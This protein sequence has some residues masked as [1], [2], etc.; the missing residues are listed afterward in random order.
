MIDYLRKL[1]LYDK[2]AIDRTIATLTEPENARARL[3]LAHL[4]WAEKIWMMR[5][6]G[7]DSSTQSNFDDLS[8]PECIAMAEELQDAYSKYLEE[9]DEAG[10][11]RVIS[12]RN[13]A[14]EP[15][16]TPIRDILMHVAIHGA[17]HR[18]QV[19]MLVRDG[20][21]TASGTD[22]ILFTRA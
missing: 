18:G 19:A 6:L 8:L 1:Y 12:Y 5:L 4:L 3:M 15:Y 11:D 13:T 2:W 9:M 21:G 14:G 10:L 20:G 7:E 17:Y 16:Q 22:Y